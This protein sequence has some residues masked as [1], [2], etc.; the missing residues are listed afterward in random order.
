MTLSYLEITQQDLQR[1]YRLARSHL[2]DILRHHLACQA[3][4][5]HI[6]PTSP[7]LSIHSVQL[8]MFWKCSAA[9]LLT[10]AEP[11]SKPFR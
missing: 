3:S 6:A 1:E 2:P 9:A 10:S 5:S 8:S 7:P 11:P 4:A